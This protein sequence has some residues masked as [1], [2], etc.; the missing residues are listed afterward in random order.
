MRAAE[1]AQAIK[2]AVEE[3]QEEQAQLE[4]RIRELEEEKRRREAGA[5]V[6]REVEAAIAASE[7]EIAHGAEQGGETAQRVMGG[8]GH[9]DGGEVD[10]DAHSR[11][12]LA[13]LMS[14]NIPG[15][16]EYAD[17][18]DDL[19]T[20]GGAQHVA[21][22]EAEVQGQAGQ[23]STSNWPDTPVETPSIGGQVE[24]NTAGYPSSE[25]AS[26]I[27]TVSNTAQTDTSVDYGSHPPSPLLQQ[28]HAPSKQYSTNTTPAVQPRPAP[29]SDRSTLP[30]LH[31]DNILSTA[32]TSYIYS[33]QSALTA[34]C[35]SVAVLLNAEME[36]T[37]RDDVAAS[38]EAIAGL[39]KEIERLELAVREAEE[40]GRAAAGGDGEEAVGGDGEA[41]QPERHSELAPPPNPLPAQTFHPVPILRSVIQYL[42]DLTTTTQS[43]LPRAQ[44]DVA[45]FRTLKVSE[46]ARLSGVVRR[47][48]AM[49]TAPPGASGTG[50]ANAS[51]DQSR[52]PAT[53]D[54]VDTDREQS[55]STPNQDAGG[56]VEDEERY[57]EDK[58]H[59]VAGV[60]ANLRGLGGYLG[61]LIWGSQE[62]VSLLLSFCA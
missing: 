55:G 47:Y 50:G 28:H 48:L 58:K 56:T 16:Q 39:E 6:R 61:Y 34:V 15:L 51:A 35:S 3:A 54:P 38:R 26:A 21:N 17:Q 1:K 25:R 20:Q 11:S 14:G 33:P 46:E 44:E 60:R 31:S 10:A 22:G 53:E 57:L 13:A 36:K 32:H 37:L 62:F 41:P 29:T 45:L 49:D 19:G 8:D 30:P 7:A 52:G 18:V 23:P 9:G 12:I 5:E 40:R 24:S 2:K 27:N 42:L 43:R 59:H 4:E